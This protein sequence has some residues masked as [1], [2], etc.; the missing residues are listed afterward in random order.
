MNKKEKKIIYI[1]SFGGMLEFYDFMV[2]ALFLNIISKQ[3]FPSSLGDFWQYLNTLG[4]FAAGFIARPLGGIVM[5]YFGDKI[6]R[7]RMLVVSL[8]LMAI[9]TFI[10]GILPTYESIGVLAPLLL[11]LVRVMQGI[12]LGGELP[13][14]WTF[15]SE[16]VRAKKVGVAVGIL[17][18]AII[19]GVALGSIINLA[20][21]YILTPLQMHEFGFRI[22]F[23]IGGLLGFV[24]VIFRRKL[25]ET[26]IFQ[27]LQANMQLE[28]NPIKTILLRHK[29]ATF[30][31]FLATW[32][33]IVCV[34]IIL[35]F[36]PKDMMPLLKLSENAALYLQLS[37]LILFVFGAISAGILSDKIGIIKA[38]II[39]CLMLSI[40]SF[41]FFY[42]LFIASSPFGV[43]VFFYILTGFS[44][45]VITFMP[46]FII[47]SFP[48]K[49]RYSGFS[50][51]ANVSFMVFGGIT[52]ILFGILKEYYPIGISFYIIFVMLS[53]IFVATSFIYKKSCFEG[54]KD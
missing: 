54:L 17:T 7:K 22:P 46:L 51:G 52:P 30:R 11:V 45:G 3:F 47:H 1:S 37:A 6:G 14:A 48:P 28:K 53:G 24:A 34:V 26:P 36:M 49:I 15:V 23:I 42:S 35:L 32:I 4:T 38:S 8:F 39:F 9:P 29:F 19:F 13:G 43:V 41:L 16:H 10:M 33:M 40:T 5:A 31:S 12:A 25:E 20:L 50:F 21:N 44:C 18:S 2:F 27:E